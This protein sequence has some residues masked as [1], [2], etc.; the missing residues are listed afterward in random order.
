MD[1]APAGALR[2]ARDGQIEGWLHAFLTSSG[3]NIPLSEGLKRDPRWYLGPLSFPLNLLTRCLGPEQGMEY[4]VSVARWEKKTAAMCASLSRG[5][6]PPPLLAMYC[7]DGMLSVR[8][9]NHR[10]GALTQRG[11]RAY[12]TIFWFN[13]AAHVPLFEATYDAYL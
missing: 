5:W 2:A 9:G 4:P 8:D 1:F 12:W 10:H 11:V 6:E 7:D 13:N 3:N